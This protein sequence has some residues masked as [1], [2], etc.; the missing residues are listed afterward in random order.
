MLVFYILLLFILFFGAQRSPRGGFWPDAFSYQSDLPLRGFF[1]LLI[2]FHHISQQLT[3]PGSLKLLQDSGLLFVSFFFFLSGYGLMKSH[4]RNTDY[5]HVFFKRRYSKLLVPFFLCNLIYLGVDLLFGASYTPA[6]FIKCLLGLYLI[7]THAWFILTLALFYLF[8]FL[9]FRFVK[10]S[11]LQYALLFLFQISYAAFCMQRGT[12]W[13]LFE[14]PWWFNSSIL[15]LI[16]V[17]FAGFEAD[18]VPVLKKNYGIFLSLSSL[19]FF[20][21]FFI[22]VYVTD[23]FP[24]RIQDT[25]L[26]S[27]LILN[28]WFNLCWQ[29]LAVIFFCLTIL[30]F[31]LKIKC[32][33]SCLVLLGKISMELYLIHGLFIQLL[34]GQLCTVQNDYL[35]IFAVLLCSV[36]AACLLHSPL[37]F[38][39]AKTFDE[40]KKLPF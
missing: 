5:F 20:L 2:V 8:F 12:G 17:L 6:F 21:F 23:E 16:G 9:I 22:S 38:L 19:S 28:S 34:K 39:T 1:M 11:S 3:H 40:L 37:H 24:Y 4:L 27:P 26:L 30:L 7:N 10:K 33:N 32:S 18:I 14:G 15:F 35:F 25:S 29:S 13:A 31:T 36:A